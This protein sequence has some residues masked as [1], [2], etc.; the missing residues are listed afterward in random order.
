MAAI[1]RRQLEGVSFGRVVRFSL[2]DK[3]RRRVRAV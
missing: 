2:A 1:I 3:R